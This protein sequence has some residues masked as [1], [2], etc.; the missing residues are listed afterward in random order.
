MEFA[1]YHTGRCRMA[2][3]VGGPTQAAQMTEYLIG[4]SSQEAK[5][6]AVVSPR[7]LCKLA[8]AWLP[9]PEVERVEAVGRQPVVLFSLRR[10]A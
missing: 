1:T 2:E 10:A 9:Q 6:T 8:S 4:T 3:T 7:L 5:G